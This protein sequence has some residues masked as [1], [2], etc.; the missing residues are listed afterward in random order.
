M[1]RIIFW[2][3]TI[4]TPTN[5]H[6]RLC[7]RINLLY[8]STP[9]YVQGQHE[10]SICFII[11]SLHNIKVVYKSHA[12]CNACMHVAWG[13]CGCQGKLCG[14][15]GG[16]VLHLKLRNINPHNVTF[17]LMSPNPREQMFVVQISLLIVTFLSLIYHEVCH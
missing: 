15:S 14:P 7:L 17:S 9:T 10:Y 2:G 5:P 12:T 11:V 4:T 6:E 16:W 13:L 1:R 3:Y 8:T